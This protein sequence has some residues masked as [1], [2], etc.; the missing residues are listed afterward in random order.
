MKVIHNSR[1]LKY[2]DPF[3]AVT[4]GSRITI[5]IEFEDCMPESVHLLLRRDEESE[6]EALTMRECFRNDSR[7][8][9]WPDVGNI[10]KSKIVG[11]AVFRLSPFSKFGRV[12]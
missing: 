11:K 2:R 8:S 3:G 5:A 4:A 7:D 10:H 9:R 1:N 6:A 12:K